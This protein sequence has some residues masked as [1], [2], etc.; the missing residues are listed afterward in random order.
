MFLDGTRTA[1]WLS[2]VLITPYTMFCCSHE[3][4]H[5]IAASV[6]SHQLS[7]F[8]QLVIASIF[9]PYRGRQSNH[10]AVVAP[11]EAAQRHLSHHSSPHCHCMDPRLATSQ[12]PSCSLYP[13]PHHRLHPQLSGFFSPS[14]HCAGS[15][16]MPGTGSCCGDR[17]RWH[18][19]IFRTQ[20]CILFNAK[21]G[22]G[23]TSS[24]SLSCS[25]ESFDR[26]QCHL[27]SCLVISCMCLLP[28]LLPV[29]TLIAMHWH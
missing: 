29:Q 2:D 19:A 21:A 22:S 26:G 23:M 16:W 25:C 11:P 12:P 4:K 27:A 9:C 6:A 10:R 5:Y 14:R 3:Q 8:E 13:R 15:V 18:P 20:R 17:R 1:L 28:C 24:V 7:K